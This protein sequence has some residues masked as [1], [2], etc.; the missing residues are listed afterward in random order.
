[1]AGA[2]GVQRP[3]PMCG[4]AAAPPLSAWAADDEDILAR[5]GFEESLVDLLQEVGWSWTSSCGFT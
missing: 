3:M 2:G 1:M 5:T 4:P